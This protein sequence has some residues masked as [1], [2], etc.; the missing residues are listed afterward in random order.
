MP[1]SLEMNIFMIWDHG[2]VL[3]V[4]VVASWKTEAGGSL[5]GSIASLSPQPHCASSRLRCAL[6]EEADSHSGQQLRATALARV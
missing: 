4:V 5:K 3:T 2:C 6:S 1:N